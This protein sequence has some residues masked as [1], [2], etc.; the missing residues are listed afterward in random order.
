L[1]MNGVAGEITPSGQGIRAAAT[2]TDGTFG[3]DFDGAT[4]TV[5]GAYEVRGVEHSAGKSRISVAMTNNTGAAIQLESLLFDYSRWYNE[6]PTN[7]AVSYLSGDL[8]IADNTPLATFTSLNILGWASDYDDYAVALTNLADNTLANGEHAVFRL[9]ASSAIGQYTGGGIDNVAIAVSGLANYDS[10][11]A[12]FGLYTSNAW[13]SADLEPDGMDNWTEYFLGGDPTI[14][15]SAIILPMVGIEGS[16]L[17]YVYRRRSDY[18]ARGLTY[19]VEA[20]TNLVSESWSTNSVSDVGFGSIEP[21]ID[22][23][24]NRVSTEELPEQFIRLR[25]E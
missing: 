17:E 23:V 24:T 2:S 15:D 3:G 12:S 22:S 6:S 20:T 7:I 14:A 19:A 10:W 16:W 9:E 4:E 11:A 8:A 5:N 1:A 25:V 18:E 13:N 21:E